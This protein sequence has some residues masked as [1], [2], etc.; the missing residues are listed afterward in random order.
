MTLK[1]CVKT[2]RETKLTVHMKTKFVKKL[3]SNPDKFE[4]RSEQLVSC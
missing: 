3:S 1:W 4:F 2:Q